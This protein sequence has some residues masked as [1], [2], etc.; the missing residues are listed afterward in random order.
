MKEK[1]LIYDRNIQEY[2]KQIIDINIR[3]KTIR[4]LA[5]NVK[6]NLCDLRLRNGFLDITK[7]KRSTRKKQTNQDFTSIENFCT[8]MDTIKKL[9]KLTEWEKIFAN[10]ISDKGLLS[11]IYK[12]STMKRQ[13]TQL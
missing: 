2:L 13:I 1:C 7:R 3:A 8:S 5:E 12:N 6:V 9:R 4:L 11:R 10:H